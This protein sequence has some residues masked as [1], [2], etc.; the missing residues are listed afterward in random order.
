MKAEYRPVA[1]LDSL[2]PFGDP[3]DYEDY[4]ALSR[5]AE[6]IARAALELA[7]DPERTAGELASRIAASGLPE[8]DRDTALDLIEDTFKAQVRRAKETQS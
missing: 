8:D 4:L 3:V 2:P 6:A 1:A 5:M 7:T